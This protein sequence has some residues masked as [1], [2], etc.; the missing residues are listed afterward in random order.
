M[1]VL[2]LG[3]GGMLGASFARS[4][5]S[6]G[7]AVAH[8][9]QLK[10]DGGRT[11]RQL[12]HESGAEVVINCAAHTDVDG[13]EDAPELAFQVNSLL[14]GLAAQACRS[15]G[16]LLVHVSSTGC[17]GAAKLDSPYTEEDPL[18]PMTVHHRAKASGEAAV[19]EAG[20]EHL[21]LRT[22]WLFGG[23][24]GARK[25]F[26]WNRLIEARGAASL[27][28][29]PWQFGN[30][31]H[32]CDVV[33]QALDLVGRQLRGT[34]NCVAGGRASRFEYVAEIVAAANLECPVVRSAEPFRRRAPVSANESAIN[35]RLG[36]LGLDKMPSWREALR[37]YVQELIASPAWRDGAVVPLDGR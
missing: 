14:P 20:C 32:G 33:A 17:Y 26:V 34:Y 5:D 1:K 7:L 3:A 22:G 15:A 18:A 10:L 24:P 37:S 9:D 13:A 30:P 12:V 36:L 35:W 6:A 16:A 11:L 21:I 28:S 27:T 29:D 4:L 23:A 31:T 8:R 19:R 2:L 25:N